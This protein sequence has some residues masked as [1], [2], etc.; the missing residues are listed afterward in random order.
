MKK[1]KDDE[2]KD[3]RKGTLRKL[4]KITKTVFGPINNIL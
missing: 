2:R 3:K 1:G 4:V